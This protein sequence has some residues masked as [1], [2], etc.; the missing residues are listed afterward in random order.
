[1]QRDEYNREKMTTSKDY[2][3]YET[4]LILLKT[5]YQNQ[6]LKLSLWKG[7]NN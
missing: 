3:K 4:K 5:N 7:Y 1:M 2:F 6:K